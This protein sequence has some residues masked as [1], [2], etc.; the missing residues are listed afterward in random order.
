M[1]A[2]NRPLSKE[3]ED[4]VAI[5]RP[6]SRRIIIQILP[7]S[8][9]GPPTASGTGHPW[10]ASSLITDCSHSTEAQSCVTANL[11]STQREGPVVTSQ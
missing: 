7:S 1:R 10:L 5:G 2:S 11:R 4:V 3:V 6:G 9:V 8:S